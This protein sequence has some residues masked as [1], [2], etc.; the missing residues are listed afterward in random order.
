M[1]SW[2]MADVASK[3]EI[4]RSQRAAFDELQETMAEIL[5]QQKKLGER[6]D[7]KMSAIQA[8]QKQMNEEVAKISKSVAA[9]EEFI[10]FAMANKVIDRLEQVVEQVPKDKKRKRA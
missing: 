9:I 10:C 2:N 6:L 5:T 8:S 4:A 3:K 7:R 1:G